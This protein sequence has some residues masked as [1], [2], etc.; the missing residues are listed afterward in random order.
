MVKPGERTAR[1][2][3]GPSRPQARIPGAQVVSGTQ[4]VPGA[5]VASAY[6][7]SISLTTCS[8]S[9]SVG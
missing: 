6:S 4:V 5:Q 2:G 9:R 7:S 3:R 1:A 8:G